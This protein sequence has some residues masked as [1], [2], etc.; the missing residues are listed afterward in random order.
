MLTH[1]RS[2][3]TTADTHAAKVLLALARPALLI[4]SRAVSA[5]T[6][7][8]AAASCEDSAASRD[9]ASWTCSGAIKPET[10]RAVQSGGEGGLARQ[11]LLELQCRGDS[12]ECRITNAKLLLGQVVSP[13]VLSKAEHQGRNND[14][15]ITG[16]AGPQAPWM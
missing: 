1:A 13:E 4:C 12:A 2:N 3:T 14:H 11:C 5:A 10:Y 7:S 15:R 9:R 8:P 6:W 16:T